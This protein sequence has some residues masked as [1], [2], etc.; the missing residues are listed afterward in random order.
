M[1]VGNSDRPATAYAASP[2]E[3]ARTLRSASTFV[4]VRRPPQDVV[5]GN[6]ATLP[7]PP[8][9]DAPERY[10]L[11]RE[12]GRGGMGRV[13]EIFD[14]A[15]GRAVAQKAVLPGGGED[16]T[17]LLVAEA[18]TCAQLEHP[19]IVPVYDLGATPSGDPYY[20]MRSVR[21]RTLA[22]VLDGRGL[23]GESAES[24]SLARLL[25]VFRQV[26]LAIDYAHS[27]GVV[28][29]DLKPANVIVGP[30]G[31]VYVLDWGVAH[32]LE[33]SDVLHTEREQTI[34]GSPGYMA[35]EQAGG[36]VDARADVF[37]LG[38]IL[39]ELLSG[40]LP[41]EDVDVRSVASRAHVRLAAPPS[42]R[43]ASRHV[44]T[45][46]DDLVSA[47]LAPMPDERPRSARV[48]ADAVDAFLDGERA[49][50]ER[51]AE[52]DAFAAEGAAARDAYEALEKEARRLREA[53]AQLFEQIPTWESTARKEPA[54]ELT[55]QANVLAAEAAR[56]IARA[57]AAFTSA[58]GR[59]ADH[60]AARRGLA[61]LYFDHFEA[62]E[63]RGDLEQMAQ[64]L[65]LA[66]AY[67]DGALALE[68]ANEG[69]L[70]VDV[71]PGIA[72][73][74]ITCAEVRAR[75][76]L[77]ALAAPF[78]L[79]PG[80]PKRVTAGSYV[81]VLRTSSEGERRFP[82]LVQRAKVTAL[83]VRSVP[84]LPPGMI[85]VPSGPFLAHAKRGGLVSRHVDDFAIGE[86]PVTVRAY[87]AFLEQLDPEEAARR[88]PSPT[89][90]PGVVR[91]DGEWRVSEDWVEGE[92]RERVP[93]DRELDLP[94]C[95]V[96]WYDA[97]A[98]TR[99]L[100]TT[101]GLPYRL[102][103]ET[104]WDKAMRGADGRAYPM[105][106]SLDASFAKLR[107][108]R[109]EAAQLE[110]VGAF[111]LDVSPFGV[112][113]LAGGVGDWTSTFVDGEPAPAL[114]DEAT[115]LHDARQA[116][117]CGGAWSTSATASRLHYPQM[118]R[119]RVGWVGFRIALS[120]GEATADL[121][122]APMKR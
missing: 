42:E 46:F 52:A 59:I 20:T 102:P 120:L 14:R 118:V 36:H 91:V 72:Y 73:A 57:H 64:H 109:P 34:A 85:H 67:D 22:D 68:L 79:T 7:P 12:L 54:W 103:T 17:T 31:E 105:S 114:A 56:A 122:I 45:A 84:P 86:L 35:P 13:D 16:L 49:R 66:R 65:D 108:S 4:P 112:R 48:L 9:P 99:W 71:A 63:A 15:L 23:D 96:S 32:I 55:T 37:A 104:E 81:V 38:V 33:G 78:A 58:L 116:T 107:E 24:W 40:E 50:V 6:A 100:A 77:L 101:T 117:W 106:N 43:N 28:H 115:S 119:H 82:L 2:E 25:G 88:V 94:A 8:M 3:V 26:C 113:D 5:D 21:G 53:A 41:F 97:I 69:E 62:A 70:V 87:T 29:R 92:G 98:Y 95:G 1:S 89:G 27:R 80:A 110:P 93:R 30:F 61:G 11:L 44:T 83:A 60:A 75:G 74:E 19:S 47:C 76:G 10:V 111:P 90:I 39:F 51:E 121:T 18:Q